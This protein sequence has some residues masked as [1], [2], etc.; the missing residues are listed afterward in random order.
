MSY[1]AISKSEGYIMIQLNFSNDLSFESLNINKDDK[2]FIFIEKR[3]KLVELYDNITN[4]SSFNPDRQIEPDNIENFMYD[5][6]IR[7][8]LLKIFR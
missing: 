1:H 6:E 7:I 5:H 2:I 4:G 8:F 3:L